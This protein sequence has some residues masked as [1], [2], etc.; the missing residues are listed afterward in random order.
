MCVCVCVCVHVCACVCVHVCAR[1]C[2]RVHVCV[3][4]CSVPEAITGSRINS[5]V[6]GHR[7]SSSTPS[8][9]NTKTNKQKT[10]IRMSLSAWR[11]VVHTEVRTVLQH[12]LNWLYKTANVTLLLRVFKNENGF[13]VKPSPLVELS[14]SLV[15]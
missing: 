5:R 6:M 15:K 14:Q 1:V 2:V 11:N 12:A 7:N 8:S 4:V 3:S 9:E 13:I 10:W